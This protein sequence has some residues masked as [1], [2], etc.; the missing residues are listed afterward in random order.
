MDRINLSSELA[1]IKSQLKESK[2]PLI[3]LG[4][5]V[6][7]SGAQT[8]VKQLIDRLQIPFVVSWGGF[9]TIPHDH[10]LFVG[11][12]GVYG[13]RGGNY[14]VQNCDFLL[15]IGSRLDTR[16]TGGQLQS[17]S[18]DSYKVMVDIDPNEVYKDRGIK[19][20]LPIVCDAKD[21]IMSFINVAY[22]VTLEEEWSNSITKWKN[23]KEKRELKNNI[24]I[25]IN[26]FIFF[27]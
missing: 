12:I 17:F 26:F 22:P 10:S 11:D 6:K 19:I 25:Y 1:Q 4:Q 23:L 9:D 2:R 3:L 24:L 21:F 15:S 5:G 13:S 20:D 14:A 16:Q 8:Y 27:S 18:R 7:L